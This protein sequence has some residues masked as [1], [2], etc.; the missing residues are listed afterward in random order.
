MIDAPGVAGAPSGDT[1]DEFTSAEQA[2]IALLSSL[3]LASLR[4]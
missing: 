4:Y 3:G 1:V 2:L